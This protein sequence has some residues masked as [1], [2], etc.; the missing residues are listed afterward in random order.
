MILALWR[1]LASVVCV[2]VPM[3]KSLYTIP[4]KEKAW[5]T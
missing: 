3:K 4:Y 5:K 2:H 1:M